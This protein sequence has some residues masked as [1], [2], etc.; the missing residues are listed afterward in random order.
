MKVQ[1]PYDLRKGER[2]SFENGVHTLKVYSNDKPHSK[3]SHTRPRTEVRIAGY[4]YSSGVWQFEGQGF[5]PG[6]TSGVCIMQVFGA[7]G[8]ATTLMLRVYGLFSWLLLLAEGRVDSGSTNADPTRGFVALPLTASHMKVQWPYD[9]R[10]EERYSFAN[11]VH[12]L[13]VYSNDKPFKQHSPTKPRTEVHITGYDYS[14]GVWQFEGHGF[15]PSG[16]SGVCIMQVFGASEH[17]STLMVRVYGG[18]LAIYRSKVL[19]DIYDRWFRLNVIHNVDDGE[20]KVYVDRSLVY[21]GPDHGGKSHY[22][23]FGVYAQN[24][25]SRLMESRWKGI[26]ILRKKS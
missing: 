25:D 16:T 19:P 23:K 18:N 15:V 10:K 2:Y 8:H 6:G 7:S 17:A 14:S 3:E 13:K 4:D 24:D 22:F 5:V 20:V 21:K 9:L 11:G 12:T 26:K 1:W